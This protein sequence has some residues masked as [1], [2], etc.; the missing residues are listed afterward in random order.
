MDRIERHTPLA[1]SLLVA[2]LGLSS[3]PTG[4]CQVA[5]EVGSCPCPWIDSSEYRSLA[6]A[7]ATLRN[8]PVAIMVRDTW[9]V[10]GDVMVPSNVSLY[11]ANGGNLDAGTNSVIIHGTLHADPNT[12]IFLANEPGQI[13][14]A[15]ES[16]GAVYPAWWNT[17]GWGAA[18]DAA[19]QAAADS[20]AELTIPAGT[21]PIENGIT[22]TLA[23]SHLRVRGIGF[24]TLV[25][26]LEGTH[27]ALWHIDGGRDGR[28]PH[29]GRC[30]IARGLG[31]STDSW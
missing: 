20:G 8:D 26:A 22:T 9:K 31:R 12:P 18:F 29:D 3:A 27:E 16:I 30:R 28:L 7:L 17:S 2:A 19:A 6:S 24:P 1:I 21:Y 10:G 14:F 11:F 25:N 23:E 5:L 4:S 13:T 15:A